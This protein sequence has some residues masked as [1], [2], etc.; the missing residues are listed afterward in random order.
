MSSKGR[1]TTF[2][3][4]T[5]YCGN[6]II[7]NLITITNNKTSWYDMSLSKMGDQRNKQKGS[8]KICLDREWWLLFGKLLGEV[9]VINNKV[10][11]GKFWERKTQLLCHALFGQMDSQ[12]FQWSPKSWIW[13]F[14]SNQIYDLFS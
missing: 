2:C 9:Q 6:F 4:I 3:E 12:A 7:I 1:Y 14:T 5:L 8:D 11:G 10:R 13:Y